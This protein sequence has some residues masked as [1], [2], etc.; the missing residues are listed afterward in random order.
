MSMMLAR[1]PLPAL[2]A[3]AAIMSGL[4]FFA[5]MAIVEESRYVPGVDLAQD[6]TWLTAVFLGIAVGVT[7][8]VQESLARKRDG[9][10]ERARYLK[11]VASAQPSGDV[12][13]WAE[14]IHRDRKS[15]NV[16][17]IVGLALAGLGVVGIVVGPL[18]AAFVVLI[19]AAVSAGF[20][21][22]TRNRLQT[23]S[24]NLAIP[25]E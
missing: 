10:A 11:A 22:R 1:L 21:W 4:G 6:R 20:D 2:F 7:Q 17:L 13:R 25:T 24:E 5:L 15:I 18:W 19:F 14:W 23:L 3:V 16:P 9:A 12:S 8:T